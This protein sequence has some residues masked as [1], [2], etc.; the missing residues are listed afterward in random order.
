MAFNITKGQPNA[1][2]FLT[3]ENNSSYEVF[4][5]KETNKQTKS[6]YLIKLPSL[7]A[8]VIGHMEGRG[9]CLNHHKN[10]KSR[11]CGKL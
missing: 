8:S 2:C 1:V 10:S 3:K 6:L 7:T 11:M 9:T 4:I 5:P